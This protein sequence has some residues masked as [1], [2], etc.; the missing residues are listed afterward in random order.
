ML[1]DIKSPLNGFDSRSD[2]KLVTEKQE[3]RK[4]WTEAQTNNGKKKKNRKEG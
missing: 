4:C 2:R 3:K 1:S